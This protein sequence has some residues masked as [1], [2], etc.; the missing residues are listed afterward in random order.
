MTFRQDSLWGTNLSMK[1]MVKRL[2]ES[3]PSEKYSTILN[4][5]GGKNYLGACYNISGLVC[6]SF[7]TASEYAAWFDTSVKPLFHVQPQPQ[8]AADTD[9][10]LEPM[11]KKAKINDSPSPPVAAVQE[12]EEEPAACGCRSF[13]YVN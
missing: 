6:S 1:A 12:E 9:G 2:V 7:K 10:N 13:T 5:G 11:L 3:D 8:P 4:S